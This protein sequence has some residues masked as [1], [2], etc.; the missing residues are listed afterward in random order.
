M[1]TTASST[2]LALLLVP[3]FALSALS[4]TGCK[5]A[6]EKR[7]EQ[8]KLEKGLKEGLLMATLKPSIDKAKADVAANKDPHDDCQAI[9]GTNAYEMSKWTSADGVALNKA[10]QTACDGDGPANRL[11]KSL[12][13]A[14]DTVQKDRASASTMLNADLVLLKSDCDAS[15]QKLWTD[16][17]DKEQLNDLPSVKAYR[18]SLTKYCTADNLASP[19][20]A[21]APAAKAASSAVKPKKK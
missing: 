20:A 21:A 5:S 10:Y 13:E 7:A 11:N 15:Q 19:A 18:A 17:W 3:A 2:L 14:G 4:L 6:A 1:R 8:D 9:S 12:T 16:G